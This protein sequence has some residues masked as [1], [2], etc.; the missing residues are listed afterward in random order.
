MASLNE[1]QDIHHV[2]V[3][4]HLS[5]IF[6]CK[7]LKKYF[8]T[9]GEDSILNIWS[10]EGQL[11][12]KIEAHQGS[13]IWAFDCDEDGNRLVVG[14]GNGGIT[15]YPMIVDQFQEKMKLP[16][17]EKPKLMGIL[18]SNNVIAVSEKSILYHFIGSKNIWNKIAHFQDTKSYILLQVSHCRKL[19]AL[20]GKVTDFI[21]LIL[22]VKLLS[23]F[24]I[25]G[26]WMGRKI[27]FY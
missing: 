8:L 27:A 25:T 19:I 1:D 20:A 11:L 6:R 14:G 5:R 4:G 24:I 2:Q 23:F 21:T 9:A 26:E 13:P 7:V 15:V 3:Y 17:L 12:R 18:S 22:K 16:D 10:H